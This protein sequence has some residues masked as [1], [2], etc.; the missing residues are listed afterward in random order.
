MIKINDKIM[1]VILQTA[2]KVH[3]DFLQKIYNTEGQPDKK[4]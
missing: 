4:I 2:I 1:S 3:F